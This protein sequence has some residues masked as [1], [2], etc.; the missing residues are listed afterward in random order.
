MKRKVLLIARILVVGIIVALYLLGF[1]YGYSRVEI[2]Y[3]TY[4]AIIGAIIL[5]VVLFVTLVF[6]GNFINSLMGVRKQPSLYDE[7]RSILRDTLLPLGF[8]E[9]EQ[10]A[11]WVRT[12]EFSRGNYL[13]KLGAH[14]ADGEFFLTA[15]SQPQGAKKFYKLHDFSVEGNESIA[16]AFKTQITKKLNAWLTERKFE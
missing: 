16:N 10:N 2:R 4:L 9:H 12:V 11:G 6:I 13:L 8:E 14:M 1:S 3:F 7:V 15:D 5:L